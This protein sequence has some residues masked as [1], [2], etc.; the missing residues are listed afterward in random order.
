M[1]AH[2]N[3]IINHVKMVYCVMEIN[4]HGNHIYFVIYVINN[5]N[6]NNRKIK[7]TEQ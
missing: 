5:V 2:K 4:E 7:L 1:S 3:L 6:Y